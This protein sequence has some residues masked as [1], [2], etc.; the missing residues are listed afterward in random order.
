MKINQLTQPQ[1]LEDWKFYG[2]NVEKE[3]EELKTIYLTPTNLGRTYLELTGDL[4]EIEEMIIK[5]NQQ[6]HTH[7][8]DQSDDR[9]TDLERALIVAK[10]LNQIYSFGLLTWQDAET[11]PGAFA[12]VRLNYPKFWHLAI[13]WA[14]G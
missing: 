6:V 8:R 3:I 11:L 9:R 13:V 5:H 10:C 4:E 2:I 7:R 1:N 12:K 14:W